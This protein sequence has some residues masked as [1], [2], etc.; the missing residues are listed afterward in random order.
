MN[1]GGEVGGCVAIVVGGLFFFW[2]RTKSDCDMITEIVERNNWQLLSI[3]R[4]F[5]GIRSYSFDYYVNYLDVDGVEQT[6]RCRV[7]DHSRVRWLDVEP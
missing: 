6:R 4:D 5:W 2:L 1:I 3:D 7:Y